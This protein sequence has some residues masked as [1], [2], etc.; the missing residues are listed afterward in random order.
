MIYLTRLTRALLFS[1]CFLTAIS[2]MAET[3]HA[4]T[5]FVGTCNPRFPEYTT[6]QAGVTAAGAGGTVY[7]CPGTYPEQVTILTKLT[8]Y[9]YPDGSNE[10]PVIV[11]PANGL[12][13]N[14]TDI[15][16]NPVAA[17][18][19]V[20]AG[21]GNSVTIGRI[22]VD[23]TGNN[24]PGCG[25]DQLEGI[26][27][28]NTSGTITYTVARNQ[29]ETDFAD[30]GGCQTGLAI[31]VEG[32]TTAM[33]VSI[34]NN[35]VHAYQKNGITASGAG[36]GL[37]SVGPSVTISDNY[38]TGMGATEMNWAGLF[39]SQPWAGAGEN[40]IQVGFGATG[41]VTANIVNDN[42]WSM[43]NS[44]QP[45]NAASG[46]LIFASPGISVTG[47]YVG[48]AQFGIVADTDGFGFCGPP[49]A[50]FSC[51]VADDTT[52][53][54][55][56]VIGTQIFDGIDACSNGNTV[57]S[58]D[59]FGSTESGVHVDDTCTSSTY[60]TTSGNNNNATRNIINEACA[61]ILTGT[62]T[63][64][65]LSPNTLYN[66]TTTTL[67]GDVCPAAPLADIKSSAQPRKA[68]P[69]P[70]RLYRR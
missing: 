67:G 1:L 61:G 3:A 46:I 57:E 11:P 32:T 30:Y 15:F 13:Q 70:Y 20:N 52:I 44:S 53:T 64:N 31:N 48:S 7:V 22:T 58:N 35:S 9:G 39:A 65:T 54:D 51:G 60:G 17:Q 36:T 10:G 47:N 4:V 6:I 18:I 16:G 33:A 26:Y 40:G 43:D 37:G 2:F 29:Y 50:P 12:G 23:G 55:N 8:L 45:G 42:I 34:T 38:V 27:Y 56:H 24:V 5:V 25:P 59:I 63:G 66:V 21:A 68:R 62:G 28:Q 41:K 14:A 69:S 19:F 49:T